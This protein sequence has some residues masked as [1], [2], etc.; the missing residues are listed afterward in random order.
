MPSMDRIRNTD[1]VVVH[2]W[3]VYQGADDTWWATRER[4]IL[5]T[6]TS[7]ELLLRI[8]EATGWPPD[9]ED[10]RGHLKRAIE[11]TEWSRREEEL[12]AQRRAQRQ[13]ESERR[14]LPAMWWYRQ[15]VPQRRER[16]VPGL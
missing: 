14:P 16:E 12:Y 3:L 6:N 11:R 4:S 9:L 7:D 15:G 8:A 13:Q 10:L 2:D 1:G 5:S